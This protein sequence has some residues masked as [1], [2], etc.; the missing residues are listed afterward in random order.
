MRLFLP[1]ILALYFHTAY[2]KGFGLLSR[3][4]ETQS[5]RQRNEYGTLA[6]V[7]ES[8]SSHKDSTAE[9]ADKGIQ[10]LL[11]VR[12][13]ISSLNNEIRL[14]KKELNIASPTQIQSVSG[15]SASTVSSVNPVEHESGSLI[16]W[17]NEG[18][19]RPFSVQ[20]TIDADLK[21]MRALGIKIPR[22]AFEKGVK[23][24]KLSDHYYTNNKVSAHDSSLPVS[25]VSAQFPGDENR[26]ADTNSAPASQIITDHVH[27]NSPAHDHVTALSPPQQSDQWVHREEDKLRV[28]KDAFVNILNKVRRVS[29][30]KN[31]IIGRHID[32]LSEEN[33]QHLRYQHARTSKASVERAALP[34]VE[35]EYHL[36][37]MKHPIVSPSSVE[38]PTVD[39]HTQHRDSE[40]QAV[41]LK[42]EERL[43]RMA[44]ESKANEVRPHHT[45]KI[46]QPIEREDSAE[47]NLESD[48]KML[49]SDEKPFELQQAAAKRRLVQRH[50]QYKISAE[51][52]LVELRRRQQW[53]DMKIAT[54]S[55]REQIDRMEAHKAAERIQ[56]RIEREKSRIAIIKARDLLLQKQ[57]LLMKQNSLLEKR[58]VQAKE[59]KEKEEDIGREQLRREAVHKQVLG[60]I[61]RIKSHEKAAAEALAAKHRLWDATERKRQELRRAAVAKKR[62]AY[63]AAQSRRES[64]RIV[65]DMLLKAKERELSDLEREASRARAGV[66]SMPAAP[67]FIGAAWGSPAPSR[68]G[69][70]LS[71][72]PEELSTSDIRREYQ[73]ARLQVVA[74]KAAERRARQQLDRVR[75]REILG[76]AAGPGGAQEVANA[77]EAL[78]MAQRRVAGRVAQE[79]ALQHR[80]FESEAPG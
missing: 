40:I 8:L 34:G 11:N 2:S 42:H 52:R 25:K 56:Q 3:I 39:K 43:L 30:V 17:N 41:E 70:G 44:Q 5:S 66:V 16:S 71:A 55:K 51:A 20:A 58:N 23:S 47:Q 24:Y 10:S 46:A 60:D 65:E 75:S 18:N 73:A 4:K 57:R 64:D 63:E 1:C 69:G 31:E 26:V 32:S 62:A 13:E 74:S 59:L 50:L 15:T 76:L 67:V 28:M 53:K 7:P 14:E 61:S 45:Q 21:S 35:K 79:H 49:K 27:V 72:Q 12:S 77:R 38:I 54:D 78:R 36:K 33:E 29:P 9:E 48:M 68:V 19:N 6:F 37:Q 22:S 80:L